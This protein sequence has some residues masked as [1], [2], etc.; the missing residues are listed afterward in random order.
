MRW[1]DIKGSCAVKLCLLAGGDLESL[2]GEILMELYIL[3]RASVI[4][5]CFNARC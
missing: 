5:F 2:V 3:L 4:T 1:F